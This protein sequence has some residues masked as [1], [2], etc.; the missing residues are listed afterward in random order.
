VQVRG[1]FYNPP[2]RKL[3]K[4]LNAGTLPGRLEQVLQQAE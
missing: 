3:V 2:L 1:Y 4:M